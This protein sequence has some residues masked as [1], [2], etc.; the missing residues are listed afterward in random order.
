[1]TD[2]IINYLR[3][4]YPK[5][6]YCDIDLT[7]NS[8]YDKVF[9]EMVDDVRVKFLEEPQYDLANETVEQYIESEVV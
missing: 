7:K 9:F 5:A 8:T 3:N 4:K 1:M 6:I 2:K